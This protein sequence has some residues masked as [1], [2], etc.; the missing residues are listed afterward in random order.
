MRRRRS[1]FLAPFPLALLL[2]LSLSAVRARARTLF[3]YKTHSPTEA[4]LARLCALA[5]RARAA[6]FPT[7]VVLLDFSRPNGT[8]L[9]PPTSSWCDSPVN[10]ERVTTGE[11]RRAF[12]VSSA[13]MLLAHSYQLSIVPE[14][15]FHARHG[16]TRDYE[17]V[18]VFEQDVGWVGDLFDFFPSYAVDKEDFLCDKVVRRE[19][20]PDAWATRGTGPAW[21]PP[22]NW[23]FPWWDAHSG[24]ASELPQRVLCGAYVVRYSRRLLDTLTQRYAVSGAW[25]HCEFF[26]A[27]VCDSGLNLTFDG[28]CRVG[29]IRGKLHSNPNMFFAPNF[30]VSMPAESVANERNARRNAEAR[31]DFLR[32]EAK[33]GPGGRPKLFHPLKY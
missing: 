19:V 24:W 25:A 8:T 7:S 23:N 21:K 29:N 5:R 15:A 32:W 3:L 30:R 10:V 20:P 16:A 4:Q 17:F 14:L 13:E 9:L 28:G 1:A 22:K 26:P 18:W 31:D 12:G 33:T 2:L 11:L 27:T 6:A